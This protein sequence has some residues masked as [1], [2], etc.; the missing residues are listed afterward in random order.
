[1]TPRIEALA[2]V[3]AGDG[4]DA[5][6]AQTPVSMGYLHGLHENAHERFLTLA[7]SSRGEVRLLA[8]ALSETQARRAGIE[9]VRVWRDG[10]DPGKL[11]EQLAED[12]GL[13]SAIIAVDDQMPAHMLLK[14]QS[15]LPAALFKAGD[16]TLSTLMSRK[17]PS[18]LEVLRQ[19]ATIAD[20]AY[21]MV[22]PKIK[23]GQTELEIDRMLVETMQELGGSPFFCIVAAGA[24]AAEPH[25]LSNET[26]VRDGDVLLLDFG[27]DFKGYKSDI[28]RCV[29]VGSADPEAAKVYEIVLRAHHAGRTA[30][31]PGVTGAQVD[32]AARKVIEDA[33]YGPNFF[34]RTGH[35]LGMQGHEQPNIVADNDEPLEPGNVFSIEPGIYLAGKF[36][37]RIEN[38]VTVTAT[39]HES[40]N[41]EPSATLVSI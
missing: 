15:V 28:T 13:R 25:H 21:R 18:E 17:D 14:L 41:E 9:D 33:G 4:L 12:W 23:A 16:R 35:G 38:I 6:L 19:A 36:G 29:S 22:L 34:H 30:I 20:W 3:L 7:I 31:K 11:V 1:M 2:K 8:P 24:G 27:C 26:V 32:A 37:I 10:E 39:G 40:F 5:Y